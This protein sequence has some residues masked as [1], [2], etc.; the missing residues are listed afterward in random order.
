MATQ[1]VTLQ[2]STRTET[3][4]GPARRLRA[5]GFIPGICY[6]HDMEPISLAIDLEEIDKLLE[7][8]HRLNTVFALEIEGAGS[9]DNMM[10]RD[11]QVEP[12]LRDLEHVDFISLD[13]EVPVNVKV[14]VTTSGK[15]RG[16]R[17]GGRLQMI[18][19]Q[20]P[21]SCRPADI[22]VA[23]DVDVTALGPEESMLASQLPFPEGVEPAFTSDF[24]VARVQMPRQK[25]APG[26]EA[27]AEAGA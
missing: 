14:P 5:K 13:P 18:Q 12:V 9:F 7:S 22:P 24:A 21:V 27:A 25:L 15:P 4:K 6:G 3:G 11:Y 16:V 20:V 17:M 8:P 19:L 23:I 26:A 1:K 10:L 2:A